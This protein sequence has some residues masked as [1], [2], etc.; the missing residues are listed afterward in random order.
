VLTEA[1]RSASEFEKMGGRRQ[2]ETSPQVGGAA[3][4]LGILK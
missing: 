3:D 1:S 4:P 2:Q